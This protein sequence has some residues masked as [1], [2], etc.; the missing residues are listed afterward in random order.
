[1]MMM[2]MMMPNKTLALTKTCQVSVCA[3][4]TLPSPSSEGRGGGVLYTGYYFS[5]EYPPNLE[6]VLSLK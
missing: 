4:Y 6:Y 5:S 1:M 2:M 3:L